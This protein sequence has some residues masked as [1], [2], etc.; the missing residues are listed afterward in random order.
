M[1]RI[2]RNPRSSKRRYDGAKFLRF[3]LNKANNLQCE[4]RLSK[5]QIAR[6]EKQ[7]EITKIQN[8][9]K[10]IHAELDRTSR[11]EDR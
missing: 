9:L 2:K 8:R 1:A 10:E 4:E 5:A 6:R 11:G 7:T 3:F